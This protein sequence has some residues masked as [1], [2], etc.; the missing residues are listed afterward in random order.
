MAVIIV[1]Q[2]GPHPP[3]GTVPKDACHHEISDRGI[4]DFEHVDE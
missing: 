4:G 2:D 3:R 1:L